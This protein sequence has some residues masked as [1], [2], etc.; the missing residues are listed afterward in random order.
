MKLSIITICYNSEKFIEKTIQSVLSQTFTDYEFII[1]D[2]KSTDKTL[3]IINKFRDDIDL[4]ISE[5]DSGIYNAQNKGVQHAKGEYLFFLNS[6]DCFFENDTLENIFSYCNNESILYGDIVNDWADTENIWGQ[7]G[8]QFRSYPE[9]ID[10]A[11]WLHDFLCHQVVFC[12]KELFE[13]YGS[14]D[15]S[16]RYAADHDFFYRIWFK[17]NVTKKHVPIVVTLYEMGGVSIQIE[18]RD[19]VLKEINI[20]QERNF[21]KENSKNGKSKFIQTLHLLKLSPL[22]K[23]YAFIKVSIFKNKNIQNIWDTSSVKSKVLLVNTFDIEGGAAKAVHRIYNALKNSNFQ[24]QYLVAHKF[25]HDPKILRLNNLHGVQKVIND[26]L[27]IPK[28]LKTRKIFKT[29]KTSNS[30]LHSIAYASNYDLV[31][32]IKLMKPDIVHLHW[33]QYD[34]I[35]IE[36]LSEIQIPIVWTIHDMW[37]VCGA[38]HYSEDFRYKEG[39]HDHNRASSESGFDLN[40]WVWRRKLKTFSKMKNVIPVGVSNW[41]KEVCQE[42]ILFKNHKTEVVCNGLDINV[43]KPRDKTFVKEYFKIKDSK[44]IILFGALSFT[45]DHRKG[46]HFLLEALKILNKTPIS[47]RYQ[48]VLFGSDAVQKIEGLSI[49]QTSLGKINHDS[50]LSFA[51]S[52]ADVMVVPSLQESF[53]QTAAESISCGT[54]VVCFD[55]TGLKDIV[56]HKVNGFRAEPNS[57]EDLA[58]GIL[59]VLENEERRIELSKK[60]RQK[61][62]EQF[63]YKILAEKYSSIYD[64]ILKE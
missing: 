15:E 44:K 27:K 33:I 20:A 63:S 58:N 24:V 50:I 52:L 36:K 18:N 16:Y 45:S 28:V 8:Y 9:H 2:G 60:A 30:I 13:D 29:F 25:S 7:K 57:P 53:G 12:K 34:F 40:Q 21:K 42:S 5:K 62:V 35:T 17:P 1:I 19:K 3:E 4:I 11:Y 39:Y 6:G 10:Q 61:A 59:W 56:E 23:L 41:M 26:L 22:I 64:S 46:F 47:E 43:F 51:Y 32:A 38:E 31:D 48:L 55:S 49:Q 14:F 54:P 37:P